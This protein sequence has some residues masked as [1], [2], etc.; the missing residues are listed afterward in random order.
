MPP[1]YRTMNQAELLDA[2]RA[3]RT[4]PALERPVAH[5]E[6]LIHELQVHQI[7]LEMQNRELREAQHALE[8]SRSRYADLYD[9]APVGYCTLDGQGKMLEANLSF[10]TILGE[11]RSGLTGQW[12]APFLKAEDRKVLQE[13][14]AR[15]SAQQARLTTEL[16]LEL[17]ERGRLAV[18]MDT[19]PIV[20]GGK[21][22]GFRA[23]FTDISERK[24]GE[25]HL[26]FLAD[27]SQVL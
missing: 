12:L 22:T 27:A 8:E 5:V 1:E 2:L 6:Q 16:T 4:D 18:Q 20:E 13:H 17:R 11:K 10:T 15:C 23:A 9:F 21:L 25:T 24:K 7:E 26:R 19:V 3:L 14:L